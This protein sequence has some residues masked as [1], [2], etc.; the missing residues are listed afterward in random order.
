MAGVNM[1]KFNEC[2]LVHEQCG[3]IIDRDEEKQVCRECGQTVPV[4]S[5]I[6]IQEKRD[7]DREMVESLSLDTR[8]SLHYNAME[9]WTRN[10]MRLKAE[11]KEHGSDTE[12]SA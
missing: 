12:V 2:V 9:S 10:Q 8:S 6:P 1:D 4:E 5:T 11:I 7:L 3:G